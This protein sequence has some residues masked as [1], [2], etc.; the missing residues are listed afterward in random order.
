M[1]TES[2]HALYITLAVAFLAVKKYGAI[3]GQRK[4]GEQRLE[5]YVMSSF[6]VVNLHDLLSNYPGSICHVI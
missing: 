4:C 1:R 6:T 3:W 2:S 5:M